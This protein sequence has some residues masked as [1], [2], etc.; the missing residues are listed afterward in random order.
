MLPGKF[1]FSIDRNPLDPKSRIQPSPTMRLSDLPPEVLSLILANIDIVKLLRLRAVCTQW[2]ETIEALCHLKQ[3]LL[4]IYGTC[5]FRYECFE[6]LWLDPPK[7]DGIR[8][9]IDESTIVHCSGAVPHAFCA[10]LHRLFPN[11][12]ALAIEDTFVDCIS[13]TTVLTM[14]NQ[15]QQLTTLAIDKVI[16]PPQNGPA[17]CDRLNS[18]V[19]LRQV[20]LGLRIKVTASQLAPT[21][22]RLDRFAIESYDKSSAAMLQHL[23]GHCTH[24]W[25]DDSP[26]TIAQSGASFNPQLLGQLTHLR[27]ESPLDATTLSQLFKHATKLQYLRIDSYDCFSSV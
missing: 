4:L 20:S 12:Q 14:L 18:M 27:L 2:D 16:F 10:F 22:A 8:C 1:P 15:W 26:L 9:R 7:F 24:L 17:L 11:L 25:Y 13:A 5:R 6:K 3:S 19:S 21:L 23:G